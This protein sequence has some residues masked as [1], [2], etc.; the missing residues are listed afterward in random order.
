MRDFVNMNAQMEAEYNKY[1][2]TVRP[3]IVSTDPK[4]KGLVQEVNELT[5]YKVPQIK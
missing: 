4:L 5:V 2:K 1:L 3:P